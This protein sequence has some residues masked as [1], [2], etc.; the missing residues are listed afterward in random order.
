M[1]RD[2][3]FGEVLLRGRDGCVKV[4]THDC[5]RVVEGRKKLLLLSMPVAM[6]CL[7][8]AMY[9]LLERAISRTPSPKPAY[10]CNRKD[11]I[12]QLRQH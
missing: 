7:L 11:C 3:H 6:I 8:T 2:L 12:D 9:L 4:G 10:F 5:G 1:P